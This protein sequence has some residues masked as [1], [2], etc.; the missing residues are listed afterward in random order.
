MFHYHFGSQTCDEPLKLDHKKVNSSSW[1]SK[2]Y[3]K[4]HKTEPEIILCT[5]S[6]IIKIQ[7]K[8]S[9]KEK[10]LTERAEMKTPNE[11]DYPV[12]LYTAIRG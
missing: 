11:L 3:Q 6:K 1:H 8:N 5:P 7:E 10:S 9:L 2:S 12:K 4:I